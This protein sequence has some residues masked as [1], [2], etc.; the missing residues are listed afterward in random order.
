MNWKA[1]CLGAAAGIIGGFAIKKAMTNKGS[2]SPEK[3]LEHVKTQFN[4]EGPINGSWIHM[5][6]ESYEKEKVR[7]QVY[8]GGI[9][10][11]EN[12]ANEQYEFIADALTGAILEV[13]PLTQ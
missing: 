6:T 5:E 3:V 1:F 4:E 10:T 12:G 2:V 8:K 9:S 7:Y 13:H 11:Y